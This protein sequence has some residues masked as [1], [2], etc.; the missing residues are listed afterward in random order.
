MGAPRAYTRQVTTEE[1][2]L[3]DQRAHVWV[4]IDAGKTHHWVTA[5]DDQGAMLWTKKVSNDEGA[6]LDSLAE[7]LALGE[8]FTDRKSVV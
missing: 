6:I 3:N 1:D 2:G 4:G 8:N 7:V 5:I